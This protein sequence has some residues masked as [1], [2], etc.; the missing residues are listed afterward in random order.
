MSKIYVFDLDNTLCKTEGSKYLESVPY[1]ERIKKVNKLYDEGNTIIVETARGCVSGKNWLY[2]TIDQL[3][4]LIEV[5][6]DI[7]LTLE[8][9]IHI[10][11]IFF[12]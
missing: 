9:S 11:L 2:H 5:L 10:F 6:K 7:S 8:R 1:S 12:F 4:K 3:K